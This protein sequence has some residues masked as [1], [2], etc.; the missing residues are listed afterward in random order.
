MDDY[1]QKVEK[2]L[3]DL[4]KF[5]ESHRDISRSRYH[6]RMM[7]DFI[8]KDRIGPFKD[9]LFQGMMKIEVVYEECKTYAATA[10]LYSS[11][12]IDCHTKTR[13]SDILE[14]YLLAISLQKQVF[15]NEIQ[16]ILINENCRNNIDFRT[17]F[18]LLSTESQEI[19]RKHGN[20]VLSHFRIL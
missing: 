1:E 20:Y 16:D 6:Q 15:I 11:Y 2:Y 9:T 3:E 4:R 12:P 18:N 14:W 17:H 8:R 13:T 5:K 19:L 7:L 10:Y